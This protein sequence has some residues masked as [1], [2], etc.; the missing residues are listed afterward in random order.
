MPER[1][2]EGMIRE[3]VILELAHK[4]DLTV[5]EVER[6]IREH[7]VDVEPDLRFDAL[8]LGRDEYSAAEIAD[9]LIRGNIGAYLFG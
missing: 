1:G 5:P 8:L 3:A 4:T 7:D 9:D 6:R 2:G